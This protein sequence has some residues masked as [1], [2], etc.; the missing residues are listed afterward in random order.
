MLKKT[1]SYLEGKHTNQEF[2][3]CI[4]F[5]AFWGFPLAHGNPKLSQALCSLYLNHFNC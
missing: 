2:T 5:I 4:V 3:N 1:K